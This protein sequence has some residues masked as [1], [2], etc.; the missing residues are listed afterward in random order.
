MGGEPGT[1]HPSLITHYDYSQMKLATGCHFHTN[2]HDCSA[3]TTKNENRNEYSTNYVGAG[4]PRPYD[5]R[6]WTNVDE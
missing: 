6:Q 2:A 4:L 1:H 3:V 5:D